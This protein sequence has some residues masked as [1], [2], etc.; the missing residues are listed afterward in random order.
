[1]FAVCFVRIFNTSAWLIKL[2]DIQNKHKKI[3]KK[4]QNQN[5]C[6]NFSGINYE[7]E[8]SDTQPEAAVI[9]G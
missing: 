1:M 9:D 2:S 6:V 5:F 3:H 7:S 8:A 4:K